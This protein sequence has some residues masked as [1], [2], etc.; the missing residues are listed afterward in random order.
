MKIVVVGAGASG[1]MAAIT[2]AR[3]P[4]NEVILLERNKIVGRKMFITGKG[5]CNVTNAADISEFF[6]AIPR[7]PD[8]LYSALYSFSNEMLMDWLRGKG[9]K[10]KTERGQRVFP[11]SD[12]SS[13]VIRVFT[14]ELEDLNVDVRFDTQV[15]AIK[16][17]G[18]LVTGV[19]TNRGLIT[20]DHYII[21]T[22]GGS[23]A[24]T[25]SDGAALEQLKRI[26]VKTHPFSPSLIPLTVSQKNVS[27]LAGV[28]LKNVGFT[29]LDGK[30]VL[31][32][33][34]GEMLFTHNGVSGPLV[35]SASCLRTQG[36]LTC[37]IDLKPGLTEEALEARILRDFAK[38]QNK[39]LR[40]GLTD[41]L[42]QRLIPFILERAELDGITK[43]NAVTTAQRKSLIQAIK[44]LSFTINGTRPLT[45]AII[46]RG[47]VDVNEIDPSTMKLK[48][49][50]NLSVC[51]E[52][53][54]VDAYTGGYNLQI[55]FSTGYLA[56]ASLS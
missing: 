42:I 4:S 28:S 15:S 36:E 46:S 8:F 48:R 30:R 12:K 14:R 21:A 16:V 51:G 26:G 19:K 9:L 45:E 49:F 40:N 39:D 44:H 5:R 2:A 3:E 22:G 50:K 11:L 41:L 25:G 7:N 27:E 33:D 17:E 43:V 1:M 29:L 47:G 32:K 24:L 34:L 23:Y 18:D 37:E 56:G 6:D 52:L 35:L 10:L 54:D 13:D 20:A 38:Y 53:V 55:A 31:F